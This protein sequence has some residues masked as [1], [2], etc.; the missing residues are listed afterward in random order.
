M[1]SNL[2]MKI[3]FYHYG[4][5]NQKS[6]NTILCEVAIFAGAAVGLITLFVLLLVLQKL[7]VRC[8]EDPDSYLNSRN[9]TKK[10]DN[11]TEE[12]H[13]F[14][15]LAHYDLETGEPIGSIFL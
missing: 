7:Y 6:W 12:N 9:N 14:D 1:S 2:S 15:S 5:G 3:S 8:T 13:L 10:E 11:K 4:E